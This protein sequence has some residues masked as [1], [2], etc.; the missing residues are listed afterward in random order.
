MKI[1]FVSAVFPYPLRSGGQVRMYQLLKRLSKRHEITL[2]SYI[3]KPEERQYVEKLPFIRNVHTIMRGNAWQPKYVFSSLIADYPFLYATY[4]SSKMRALVNSLAM[5]HD[6]IHAE[7]GYVWLSLPSS[8]VPVVVSEHNIE[9][10]VYARYAEHSPF[11]L[12]RPVMRWDVQKMDFWERRIW[13]SARCVTAASESDAAYMRQ[14]VDGSKVTVVPNGV[15]VAEFS[16]KSRSVSA[17]PVFLYV[18][19]FSWIQNVDAVEYLL[20][21]MWPVIIHAYPKATLRIVGDHPPSHLKSM[22]VKG[23]TWISAVPDIRNEYY[24]ADILLAPIRVGGGTK[25]KILESM[26]TG[27]PVITTKHGAQGLDVTDRREIWIAQTP[28]EVLKAVG[29]IVTGRGR[30]TILASARK[31]VERSYNWDE[32][33]KTLEA[34]WKKAYEKSN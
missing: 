13:R 31:K 7:P 25:Y 23:V 22:T 1:L 10:D 14:V 18:G 3:R 20:K 29:E 34:V 30:E 26:A 32:I 17:S 33:A 2:A 28:G 27:L 8:N 4:N 24:E 11:V 6:I 9:H 21:T 15:D 19:T 12:A 16:Y 5:T